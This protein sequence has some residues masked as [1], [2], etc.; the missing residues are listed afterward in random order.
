[1]INIVHLF[2]DMLEATLFAGIH[3]ITFARREHISAT[4]KYCGQHK[5]FVS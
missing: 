2:I 4:M 1:M 5:N 3:Y